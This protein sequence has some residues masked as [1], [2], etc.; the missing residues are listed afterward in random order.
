MLSSYG[1]EP[2]E[3]SQALSILIWNSSEL[4]MLVYYHMMIHI[5]CGQFDLTIYEGIIAL[6]T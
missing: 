1:F 4:Y 2:W 6:F 3:S 5:L